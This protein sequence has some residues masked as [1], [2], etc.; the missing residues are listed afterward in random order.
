MEVQVS[1]GFVVLAQNTEDVD[2]IRQA[3]ALALSIKTTQT[4]TKDIS[5]VTNDIVPDEYKAVFDKI[6]PIPFGNSNMN[7]PYKAE[8]RWKLYHAS[9]YDETI[10]LDTDMLVLEDIT[11]WWNY[12]S[13]FDVKFCNKIS[14]YKL[15][16]VVDT[17]NRKAFIAN[18][19]TNPYCALYYFKKSQYAYEFFK[20][21]EFVVNNWEWSWTKFAPNNYQN[22]V[23][24][25]LA[26]AVT[27]EIMCAHEEVLDINNPMEFTH[28]KVHLQDWNI[29]TESWQSNVLYNFN[30]NLT[31]GNIKQKKLF[32]YVEKD[33][34]SDEIID[35][36]TELHCG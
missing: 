17:Y 15:E 2:Y 6:I 14:N 13:N 31:V 4:T 24:M 18:N 8:N 32:H 34:L 5:L 11:S 26:V 30:G 9:P 33:F 12:C 25:D 28:M 10:V 22:W 19:L 7:S 16:S 27:I 23:S 3:Y 21:L 1:K 35:K 36:L 29:S 20:V